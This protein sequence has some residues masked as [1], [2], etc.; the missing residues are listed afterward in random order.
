MR[1]PC[2]S[3]S[4]TLLPPSLSLSLSFSR[5]LAR[6]PRSHG[7]FATSPSHFAVSV[8][9][10]PISVLRR[11]PLIFPKIPRGSRRFLFLISPLYSYCLFMGLPPHPPSTLSFPLFAR[12]LFLYLHSFH[13]LCPLIFSS[14]FLSL[15]SSLSA[16]P[17]SL[18]TL[19][20]F[21]SYLRAFP[22]AL[23]S[24]SS[25]LSLSVIY[26]SFV[27]PLCSSSS[28]SLSISPRVFLSF[29]GKQRSL[30]IS[31]S[32]FL[33]STPP[34]RIPTRDNPYKLEH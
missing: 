6:P 17:S 34:T 20:A 16:R 1:R 21:Y 5:S 29:L 4:P 23:P 27:A 15:F 31:P 10:L 32:A 30:T 14:S 13:S 33:S 22:A 28:T 7:P 3:S 12:F 19:Q 25:T 24:F 9:F 8:E 18:A 26:S 2:L 11:S